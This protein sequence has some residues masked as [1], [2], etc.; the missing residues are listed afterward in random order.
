VRGKYEKNRR[1]EKNP[2][3]K[4]ERRQMKGLLKLKG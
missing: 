4:A 3:K 2:K 1:T